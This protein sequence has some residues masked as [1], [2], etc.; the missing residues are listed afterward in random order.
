[1]TWITAAG[2]PRTYPDREVDMMKHYIRYVR[3]ALSTLAT[4]GFA[5][6]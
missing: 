2:A 6:N 3:Y 4:V 5:V 1:V